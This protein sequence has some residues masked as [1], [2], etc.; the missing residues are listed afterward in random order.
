[1]EL[2]LIVAVIASV[3]LGGG[4]GYLI[5]KKLASANFKIYLE[6]AKAKAKA[7]EHEAQI[8]LQNAKITAK[9]AEIE[10]KRNYDDEKH[11]LKSEYDAKLMQLERKEESLIKRLEK[12]L[13]EVQYE[14]KEA[15]EHSQKIDLRL[16]EIDSIKD[17]YSSSLKELK[18]ALSNVS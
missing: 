13:D 15:K 5:S 2:E 10:L 12:E 3:L 8:V 11:K 9:E 6:Q 4:V 14:K 18:N 17:K 16:R 7:I 1:M